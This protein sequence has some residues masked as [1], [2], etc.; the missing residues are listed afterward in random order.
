MME[1]HAAYDFAASGGIALHLMGSVTGDVFKNAPKVFKG[2]QF[3]HLFGPNREALTSAAM[4]LGC[5]PSWIQK[6]DDPRRMHFDLVGSKLEKAKKLCSN[7]EEA[8]L[9]SSS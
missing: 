9:T 4:S 7:Y 2:R 8:K 6:I 1:I 5:K 3:G